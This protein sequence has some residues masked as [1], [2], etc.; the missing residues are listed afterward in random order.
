MVQQERSP[1]LR[2]IQREGRNKQDARNQLDIRSLQLK[3]EKR[4]IGHVLGMPEERLPKIS[5]LGWYAE[6]EK[7]E[8]TPGKKR[9][10]LLLEETSPGGK[11]RLDGSKKNGSGETYGRRLL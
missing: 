3:I 11:Y 6:L 1:Q 2:Q 5:V 4:V 8:K 10:T 9:K 7:W